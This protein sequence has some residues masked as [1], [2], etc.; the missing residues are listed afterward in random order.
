M[1]RLIGRASRRRLLTL[2]LAGLLSLPLFFAPSVA[3][4]PSKP[5]RRFNVMTYN[6]YLGADFAPIF[7]A[8]PGP[9]LVAAAA[10][11]YDQMV[12]TDFPQR[13][14]AIAAQV[15]EHHPELIGLQEVALWQTG[16]LS[17]P[18]QLQPTYDFQEILLDA[19]A[20]HGL[21]YQPVAT[22]VNFGGALPISATTLASFSDRDVILARSDLPPSRLEISNPSAH[23]FQAMLPLSIGGNPILVP[24]GWSTVDVTYR[25]ASYRFAN[26]HLEAFHPGV[27]AAQALELAAALSA[28]PLPVVLAGDLNS[29]PTDATGAYGIM[30]GSGF[31]DSWVDAMDGLP[32]FTSGQS[33]ELTK[34]GRA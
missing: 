24:R 3:A 33:A 27:R 10:A 20:D 22:N 31:V 34:I 25:G 5:Q 28:S 17:D 30:L 2:G 16:P 9:P 18:S 23:T 4:P 13:A 11:V 21:A 32:G 8:P 19:F 26:T 14:Q 6:V 7:A 29:L 1:D 12:R 15:A